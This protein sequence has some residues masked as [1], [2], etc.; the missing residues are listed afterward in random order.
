ME[1][2]ARFP[3]CQVEHGLAAEAHPDTVYKPL[4]CKSPATP[5]STSCFLLLQCPPSSTPVLS[6]GLSFWGSIVHIWCGPER[7]KIVLPSNSMMITL[8]SHWTIAP[9]T[10]VASECAALLLVPYWPSR[11]SNGGLKYCWTSVCVQI[12]LIWHHNEPCCVQVVMLKLNHAKKLHSPVN[13]K[14][15]L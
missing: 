7:N 11:S 12:M 4:I 10:S 9:L 6:G 15:E 2:P 3:L 13:E 8:L 14:A 5:F 1:V